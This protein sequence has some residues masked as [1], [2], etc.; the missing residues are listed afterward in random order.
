MKKYS[1]SAVLALVFLA[2]GTSGKAQEG[3][4]RFVDSLTS[5][6]SNRSSHIEVEDL[7]FSNLAN[8]NV[9]RLVDEADENYFFQRGYDLNQDNL[10]NEKD[11]FELI[12]NEK[13]SPWGYYL[14]L[15]PCKG[16]Q[17]IYIEARG[18]DL[19][20]KVYHIQ[21]ML[22]LRDVKIVSP[23]C[24]SNLKFQLP[25]GDT[26]ITIQAKELIRGN[27]YEL[28]VGQAYNDTIG[29]KALDKF[30]IELWDVLS[31]KKMVDPNKSSITLNCK[32]HS[33]TLLAVF[34]W[35]DSLQVGACQTWVELIDTSGMCRQ[36]PV[37]TKFRDS[38]EY[39]LFQAFTGFKPLVPA[40]QLL[41]SQQGAKATSVKLRRSIRISEI[42][43]WTRL[44]FDKNADGL[45]SNLDGYDW[46]LDGDIEDEGEYFQTNGSDILSPYLDSIP[47]ICADFGDSLFIE[48]SITF[49]DG[50]FFIESKRLCLRTLPPYFT[51]YKL[52]YSSFIKLRPGAEANGYS[53][54]G[55]GEIK[56]SDLVKS[57]F[58]SCQ[59]T[60]DN[61]DL[62]GRSALNRISLGRTRQAP[63][64]TR[65]VLFHDCCEDRSQLLFIKIH[66]WRDNSP[67]PIIEQYTVAEIRDTL[68]ACFIFGCLGEP[69]SL[70]TIVTGSI[71]TSQGQQLKNYQVQVN[72]EPYNPFVYVNENGLFSH[73]VRLRNGFDHTYYIPEKTDDTANG[74]TTF[75]LLQI[76]RHILGKQVFSTPFQYIAADINQSGNIS[77]LDIIQLRKVI[78]NLETKFP[79]NTSWRFID[80][81]HVFHQPEEALTKYLPNR[82]LI[83]IPATS[84]RIDFIA[85]KIGD[86]NNSA[87]L[88]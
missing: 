73:Y 63:D 32:A 71:K 70:G 72:N 62:W 41:K 24:K 56:V 87:T 28:C 40:K 38:L 69:P 64:S 17:S 13:F 6:L 59:D 45:L 34:V 61:V 22:K 26:S 84:R 2:L 20:K 19:N 16:N 83:K 36:N 44:G 82:V 53:N 31:P 5:Y 54:N 15:Y 57:P 47:L 66:A 39:H 48:M 58:Y 67:N 80:A 8:L 65:K 52:V 46:N 29:L 60:S 68:N 30:S 55:I 21:K 88:K 25:P 27:V 77:T 51:N 42:N 79:N 86:L 50:S 9:R 35:K 76:Q 12:D 18:I 23:W 78:L 33:R 75:D 74:V 43:Q 85:V 81:A 7:V 37:E 14:E 10:L 3:Y 1:S 11:G 4:I 49:P